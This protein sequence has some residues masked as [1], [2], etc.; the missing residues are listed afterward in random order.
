MVNP[1]I[2]QMQDK[3]RS[4]ITIEDPKLGAVEWVVRP[5]SADTLL[6][7]LDVFNKLSKNAKGLNTDDLKDDDIN[8]VQKEILPVMRVV[9]PECVLDIPVTLDESDPRIV[10]QEALHIKDLTFKTVIGLFNHIMSISG[11]DAEADEARKKSETPTS[12]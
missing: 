2:V 12:V 7:N 4:K 1:K 5:L 10:K 6:E 3:I 9:I 8:I 11:L